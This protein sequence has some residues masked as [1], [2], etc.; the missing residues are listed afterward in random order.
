MLKVPE[1]VID[2]SAIAASLLGGDEAVDPQALSAAVDAM[3]ATGLAV[4]KALGMAARAVDTKD[5]EVTVMRG[6]G[7]GSAVC[8]AEGGRLLRSIAIEVP[9]ERWAGEVLGPK[10]ASAR[11]GVSRSTLDNWRRRNEIIALSKGLVAHAVPMEQ[12]AGGR[13][14]PGIDMVIAHSPNS[15]RV[16][17]YW[18]MNPDV[19]LGGVRP[20]DVLRDGRIDDVVMAVRRSLGPL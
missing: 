12:F 18:M 9:V 19:H 15:A 1:V 13:P 5:L 4:I 17:W 2:R 6:E 3:T 11:L 14:I 20:I 7:L 16:T 8:P 10:E